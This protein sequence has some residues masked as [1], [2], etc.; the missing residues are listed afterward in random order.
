SWLYGVAY[1][2]AVQARAGAAARRARERQVEDMPAVAP[3]DAKV[4]DELRPLLD[5]EVHRLPE[6]YR[7]PVVLCYFEGKTYAE[8][9]RLLGWA[10]G[11]VSGRLARAR[12]KLRTRLASRGLTLSAAV[13]TTALCQQGSAAV[14]AALAAATLQGVL[15]TA[16]GQAAAGL[17]SA[18]AV[19]FSQGALRVALAVKLKVLAAV[20]AAGGLVGAAV[21]LMSNSGRSVSSYLDAHGQHLVA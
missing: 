4:W 17:V 11:T 3:V 14:P 2:S 20:I 7:C 8:A 5:E 1:R 12:E 9:A 21:W 13:L 16:A 6:K 19:A 18:Q 10:E 15:S